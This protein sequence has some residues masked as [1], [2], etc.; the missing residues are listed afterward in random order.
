MQFFLNEAQEM[1][2]FSQQIRRDLHRYPELGFEEFRTADIVAH[3]LASLG[4]EVQT[5]VAKTGVVGLLDGDKPGP[6]VLARF[7]MDALP[8]QEETGTEYASR[9]PGKMHACGHDAHVAIGLTVARLLAR[10]RHLL[11]GSVKF[12]FQPAE[13]G[14]GGG[15][16][17]VLEGVL[18][19][20]NPDHVLALHIWNEHPLGWV[21][22]TAG[23]L[24]AGADV[25]KVT[26]TG[27]GGHGAMPHQTA[28]PVVASAQ[29]ITAIQTIVSRNVAPLQSAVL[30]VTQVHGGD[31]FNVIPQQVVLQ[32]T[33]RYFEPEVRHLVLE[34]LQQIVTATAQAMGCQTRLEIDDITPP[35]YNEPAIALQLQ[36]LIR[37]IAPQLHLVDN[38][39]SMVSEDMAFLLQKVPGCYF[40]VGSAFTEGENFPHH[41]PRFD[42][43]ERCLPVA[44]GLMAAFIVNLLEKTSS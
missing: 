29:L 35:V 26:V 36:T 3:E 5:G 11:T 19:N 25:F 43:D 7:D 18:E 9:L 24:L 4:M 34:R 12:V 14:R 31:A 10:H 13:E 17:M 39:R 28:D 37:Q 22:I 32:G 16:T 21:A 2:D 15:R 41:H 40:M 8:I 42:I 1:F 20:P 30:S 6:V 27:K 23:P 44:A 33:L 38:F